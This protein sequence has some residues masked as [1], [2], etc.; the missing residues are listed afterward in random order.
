MTAKA[1]AD[2]AMRRIYP[3]AKREPPQLEA[4]VM[5]AANALGLISIHGDSIPDEPK[6]FWWNEEEENGSTKQA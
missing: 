6:P 4:L 1:L 2:A 3:L 5:I